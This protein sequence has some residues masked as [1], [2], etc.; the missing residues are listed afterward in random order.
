MTL[1]KEEK[2]IVSIDAEVFDKTQYTFKMKNTPRPRASQN[3][4]GY[5][6]SSWLATTARQQGPTAEDTTQW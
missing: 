2:I 1:I 5:R 3:S 4:T 6:R